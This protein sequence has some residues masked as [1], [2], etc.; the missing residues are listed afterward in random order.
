MKNYGKRRN[1]LKTALGK[2]KKEKIKSLSKNLI[3]S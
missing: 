3:F 2:I 1:I